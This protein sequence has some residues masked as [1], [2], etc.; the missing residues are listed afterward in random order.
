MRKISVLF[1]LALLVLVPLKLTAQVTQG[2]TQGKDSAKLPKDSI[3]HMIRV[4]D[5]LLNLARRDSIE[6]AHLIQ[7]M[8]FQK[9]SLTSIIN[10]MIDERETDSVLHMHEYLRIREANRKNRMSLRSA[11][12]GIE[13]DSVRKVL[14]SVIGV[15]FDDTAYSPKP[16]MLKADMDRLVGH[17]SNDSVQ[18]RIINAKQDTIPF[19]LKNGRIDSTAFFVMNSKMDSARVFIRS[20]DKHTM[21]MWVGDD[22]LLQHLLR[23]DDTPGRIPVLWEGPNKYRVA[24]RQVPV[25][26]PKPWNLGAVFNLM[27]NQTAY[28]GWVQGGTSSITLTTAISGWANYAKGNIKWNNTLD[29]QYGVQQTELLNLRKNQDRIY[30]VSG[31]SHKAFKNFDYTVKATFE[32]QGF[33]GYIYPNDSVPVSKLMAPAN[34]NLSLGMTY[35][36]SPKLSIFATPLGGRLTF[37]LDTLA[38]DE[39]RYGLKSGHNVLAQLGASVEVKDSRVLFK[40][41]SMV[42]N[43]LLWND[44]L[45]QP[46]KINFD[47]RLNLDMKFNKYINTSFYTRMIYN[48]KIMVPIYEI[49]DGVKVKVGEGKRV[50]IMEVFGISFKYIFY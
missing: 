3:L 11:L 36:P 45:D 29:A 31:L 14:D 13:E 16:Q 25:P 43:L 47:W 19:V 48:N 24:R 18:F 21:Y 35:V 23:K 12:P 40:N 30:L 32:T 5:S 28:S 44:Y 46:Q 8:E 10:E 26:A 49:Q 6:L 41:V 39:T 1:I 17:L 37:V 4:K 9:D 2:Q 7:A 42:N 27:V 33:K 50:Q 34:L 15:V 38:I 22:L 20:L